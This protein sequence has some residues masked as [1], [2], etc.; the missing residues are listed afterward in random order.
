MKQSSL[1]CLV[2]GQ[3]QQGFK[4]LGFRGFTSLAVASGEDD[5]DRGGRVVAGEETSDELATRETIL[6]WSQR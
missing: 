1:A 6:D 5:V 4:L 3:A 2:S